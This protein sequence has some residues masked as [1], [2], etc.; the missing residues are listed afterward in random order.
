VYDS[1]S[2]SAS[3]ACT[4]MLAATPRTSTGRGIVPRTGVRLTPGQP[5]T[6]TSARLRKL[7][8]GSTTLLW[9]ARA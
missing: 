7:V 9:K 5:L 6:S 2:A 4:A 8:A 1:A 3:L